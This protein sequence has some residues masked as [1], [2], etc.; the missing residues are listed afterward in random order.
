MDFVREPFLDSAY[1]P[2]VRITVSVSAELSAETSAE[3]SAEICFGPSLVS[4]EICFG[5][6]LSEKL[7]ALRT[8]PVSPFGPTLL[9]SR[10]NL[11]NGHQ[12]PLKKIRLPCQVDKVY[13]PA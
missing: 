8:Y 7:L 6:S 12:L 1:K 5:P 10:N 11:L 2:K 3:M 9:L 13:S 4:A